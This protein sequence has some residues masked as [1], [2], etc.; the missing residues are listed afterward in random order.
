ME[1]NKFNK[2]YSKK[3]PGE[4]IEKLRLNKINENIL[5]KEWFEAL[6]LHLSERNLTD[7]EN[8][9]IDYYLTTDSETLINEGKMKKELKENEKIKQQLPSTIK[10]KKNNS[11]K[12]IAAVVIIFII[13]GGYLL[14]HSLGKSNTKVTC[15]KN[16]AYIFA[17]ERASNA[18]DIMTGDKCLSTSVNDC[19]YE[20]IFEGAKYGSDNVYD[21]TVKV[22]KSETGWDVIYCN[23]KGF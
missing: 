21:V 17:K 10:N 6:K 4:L 15:S 13:A 22:S 11:A 5:D 8:K 20:F 12:I 19:T 14:Y 23:V 1:N 7:D 9:L 16:E 3:P 2:F 18:L